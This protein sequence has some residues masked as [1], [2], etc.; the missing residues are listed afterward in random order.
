[1]T[2]AIYKKIYK[3][4]VLMREIIKAKLTLIY[5]V[6]TFVIT[7][8]LCLVITYL[9]RCNLVSV[10]AAHEQHTYF[11]CFHFFHIFVDLLDDLDWFKQR[12][13]GVIN[14]SPLA[15]GLLN[16]DA[17]WPEWHIAPKITKDVCKKAAQFCKDN[18]ADLGTYFF[19]LTKYYTFAIFCLPSKKAHVPSDR[20]CSSAGF[21]PKK[22]QIDGR[23]T[24]G[25]YIFQAEIDLSNFYS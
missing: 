9:V 7:D 2:I 3:E 14:A 18:D 1:M 15:L 11:N 20:N 19:P 21:S 4:I 6:Y 23:A 24:V 25:F 8:Y 5:Q 16:N 13:I 10:N 12:N 17:N 22:N